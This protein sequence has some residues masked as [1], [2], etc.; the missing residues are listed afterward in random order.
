MNEEGR[1]RAMGGG[2]FILFPNLIVG[3]VGWGW[4]W[5]DA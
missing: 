1:V 5:G 4:G 3:G 2:I